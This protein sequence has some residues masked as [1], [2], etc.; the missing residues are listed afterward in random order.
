M[1]SKLDK[2]C[3][4]GCGW[5]TPAIMIPGI[6]EGGSVLV[7]CP[8]CGHVHKATVP[9]SVSVSLDDTTETERA[10]LSELF[11]AADRAEETCR[12]AV[13]I[14]QELARCTHAE[15]IKADHGWCMTCGA[16]KTG[17]TWIPCVNA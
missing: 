9:A 14:C 13:A 17:N 3:S 1:T 6:H 16:R 8:Q 11:D 2:V 5:Q 7:V 15:A 4:G 10:T 12:C